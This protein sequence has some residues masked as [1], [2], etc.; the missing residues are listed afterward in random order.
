M[1]QHIKICRKYA[2][3]QNMHKKNFSFCLIY[4]FL[5]V[6][7]H[8]LYFKPNLYFYLKYANMQNP[9]STYYCYT[10][11]SYEYFQ[12]LHDK[13]L[14]IMTRQFRYSTPKIF[15]RCRQAT[16]HPGGK[17][18]LYE[19]MFVPVGIVRAIR[20]FSWRSQFCVFPAFWHPPV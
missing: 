16:R 5:E 2:K 20:S 9:N 19:N 18:S 10:V 1:H 12:I 4:S 14:G 11:H 15:L 6:L 13:V 17:E 3:I 8:Q 7:S